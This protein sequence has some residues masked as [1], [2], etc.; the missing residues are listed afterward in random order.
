MGI[1]ATVLTNY[2]NAQCLKKPEN[3]ALLRLYIYLNYL[4]FDLRENYLYY[5]CFL[6]L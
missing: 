4:G 2:Y 3:C 6:E 5:S 1:F